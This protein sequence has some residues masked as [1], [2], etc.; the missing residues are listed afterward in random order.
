MFDLGVAVFL[1]RL[2]GERFEG[3][4]GHD[5]M[6]RIGFMAQNTLGF[7]FLEETVEPGWTFHRFFVI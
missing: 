1:A 5:Q 3:T 4:L 2:V 6:C 7:A